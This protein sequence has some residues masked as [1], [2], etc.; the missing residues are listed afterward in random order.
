[1]SPGAALETAAT[2]ASQ[3]VA[4]PW[5]EPCFAPSTFG[6]GPQLGRSRDRCPPRAGTFGGFIVLLSSFK[7]FIF[8]KKM[9]L[10]PAAVRQTF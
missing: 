5:S 2:L 10:L 1:M 8:L 9:F 7:M 4:G 6:R 3:G